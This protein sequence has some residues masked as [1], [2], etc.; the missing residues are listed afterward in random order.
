VAD[1]TAQLISA[2]DLVQSTCRE[3]LQDPSDFEFCEE[4]VFKRLLFLQAQRKMAPPGRYHARE[5]TRR[6]TNNA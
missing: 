6:I 5:R 4:G 3:V 2:A 1:R